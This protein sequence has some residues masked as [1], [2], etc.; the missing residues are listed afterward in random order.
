VDTWIPP[1]AVLHSPPGCALN[2]S[3]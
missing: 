3:G 1:G 2:K